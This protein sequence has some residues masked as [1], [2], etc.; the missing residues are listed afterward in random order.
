MGLLMKQN[1]NLHTR[2]IGEKNTLFGSKGLRRYVSSTVKNDFLSATDIKCYETKSSSGRLYASQAY[3][4]LAALIDANKSKK[5]SPQMKSDFHVG[6]YKNKVE[7]LRQLHKEHEF[8]IDWEK[9]KTS[10]EPFDKGEKGPMQLRAEKIR[11]KYEPTLMDKIF[12]RTQAR[13][14]ELDSN[15]VKAKKEDQNDYRIWENL[16]KLSEGIIEKDAECMLL[17]IENMYS[18]DD[19]LELGVEIKVG[20]DSSGCIEV[21]AHAHTGKVVP[22][23]VLTLGQ[24]GKITKMDMDRASYYNLVRDYICSLTV[25]IVGDI[26]SIVPANGVIINVVD[27]QSSAEGHIEDVTILSAAID[28]ANFESLNFSV[29]N[30]FRELSNM[31]CVSDFRRTDAPGA[32]KRIVG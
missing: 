3:K 31:Y 16:V 18:F 7:L 22:H 29:I 20:A 27:S 23:Q 25:R 9:I 21:E 15:I 30:P 13:I 26:F 24:G 4:D 1:I 10:T 17:V 12:S 19:L 2:K 8:F 5:M 32:V 14:K 6:C 11:A 28:R